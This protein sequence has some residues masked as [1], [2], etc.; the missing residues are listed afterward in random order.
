MSEPSPWSKGPSMKFLDGKRRYDCLYRHRKRGEFGWTES[1]IGITA[2]KP[3]DCE[4]R[5]VQFISQRH[6][7]VEVEFIRILN[8]SDE[9]PIQTG[10]PVETVSQEKYDEIREQTMEKTEEERKERL[11]EH[12]LWIP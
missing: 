9:M 6:R 4:R 1:V 11:R 12:G 5:V 8:V 10:N 3:S 7:D 2:E